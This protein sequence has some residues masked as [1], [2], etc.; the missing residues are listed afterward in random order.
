[1]NESVARDVMLV[2]AIETADQQHVV[3]SEEDRLYA[4]RSARELAQ[5][6]ASET[7]ASPTAADFLQQRAE[8]ILRRISERNPSFA[9][10]THP[11]TLMA[12]LGMLMPLMALVFGAV[13]D[14]ITDPHRVDLLSA[15]LLLIVLWNLCVY[16]LMLLSALRILPHSLPGLQW[17]EPGLATGMSGRPRRAPGKMPAVLWSSLLG[18]FKE[19]ALASRPLNGA[20]LA[21][22][23]HLSAALFALGAVLSLYARGILSQYGAGWES[24][25]LDAS[26]VHAI[27]SAL[28]APARLVFQLPGFSVGEIDALRFMPGAVPPAVQAGA[29]WVHLYA[30]TLLLLVIV[31]RLLLAAWA[32][33]RA[34]RLRR[35]FPVPLEQPYFRRLTAF[36]GSRP[37]LLR[38]LPYSFNLSEAQD[39]GLSALATLVLGEQA[40]VM[41]RPSSS[42]GEDARIASSAPAAVNDDSPGTGDENVVTMVL[43]SLAAT[44]EPQNHGAFLQQVAQASSQPV[45]ALIDESGYV[46]RIG[47]QAGGT[48]RIAERIALWQEFCHFHGTASCIVN[49]LDA[50]ARRADLEA[51][52]AASETP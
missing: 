22:M 19:W 40:R 1:M 24:T 35:D 48:R 2:R 17:L 4:S 52:L 42:Y 18:F 10:L 43:F 6:K 46:E 32:H 12:R 47:A 44:P 34:G 8:Q 50:P 20:R 9:T 23:V 5:W 28:F 49:L 37:V 45:I 26:Q 7:G 38:V 29:R 21:R 30:A 39:R 25:F 36:L 31:P 15:P 14:H 13:T 51:A 41:L 11:R 16:A 27:L 33:R 3:L